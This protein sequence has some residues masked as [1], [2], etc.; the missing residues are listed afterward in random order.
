MPP[1]A[2]ERDKSVSHHYPL[3]RHTV[4]ELLVGNA[5]VIGVRNLAEKIERTAHIHL[6][7]CFHVEQREVYRAAPAVARL[8]G[9]ISQCEK[10][11]LLQVGVKI[12]LHSYVLILY[13]P[14]HKVLNGAGGTV[15]V[16]NLQPVALNQHLAA[17][18]FQSARRFYCEQ[19]ARLLVPVYALAYEIVA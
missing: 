15:R 4:F 1:F 9:D 10:L 19:R 5:F 12:R 16:E 3:K 6:F 14:Q 13:A 7:A 2:V 17:Y 11:L 18:G 8:L